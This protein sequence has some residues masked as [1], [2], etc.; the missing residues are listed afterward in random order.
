VRRVFCV[1]ILVILFCS[2]SLSSSLEIYRVKGLQGTADPEKGNV[3]IVSKFI[4]KS[5]Y[6]LPMNKKQEQQLANTDAQKRNLLIVAARS[7]MSTK[8]V[9]EVSATAYT[10]TG[11]PTF[12][13]VYPRIGTIAVDPKVIPLGSRMWVEGY[14]YGIAEDTGGS[15]KGNRI[16][17]FMNTK[18]ECLNWGRKRVRVFLLK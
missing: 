7:L 8:D 6:P 14:G 15:I 10:H 12:T 3:R 16:D 11:N 18:D 17:V 2:E 9:L 4:G 5:H 13:G 1:I